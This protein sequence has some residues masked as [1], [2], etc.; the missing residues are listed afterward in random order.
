MKVE[1]SGKCWGNPRDEE[2]VGG[3]IWSRYIAY[4]YKIVKE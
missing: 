3:Q 4:V 1:S 2:R